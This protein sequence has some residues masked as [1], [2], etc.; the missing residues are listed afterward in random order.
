MY[1]CMTDG[2]IRLT[3]WEM[4]V[5]SRSVSEGERM[6]TTVEGCGVEEWRG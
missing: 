2:W 4:N 3:S 5:E 1:V 6:R